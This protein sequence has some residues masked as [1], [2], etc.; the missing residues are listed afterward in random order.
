MDKNLTPDQKMAKF[1]H[2][3]GMFVNDFMN[4]SKEVPVLLTIL[5]REIIEQH[6]E[7]LSK[8]TYEKIIKMADKLLKISEKLRRE[9]KIL[10]NYRRLFEYS[11]KE[12]KEMDQIYKKK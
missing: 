6:K 10:M 8:E 1:E 5:N 3:M 4:Y 7:S 9:I 11:T 2:L 12:L